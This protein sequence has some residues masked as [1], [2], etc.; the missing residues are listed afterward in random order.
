MAN[1]DGSSNTEKEPLSTAAGNTANSGNTVREG[2]TVDDSNTVQK[3]QAELAK[4]QAQLQAHAAGTQI[5]PS[6]ATSSDAPK[7]PAKQTLAIQI[8]Q[9]PE[10][11]SLNLDWGDY[12]PSQ[13]QSLLSDPSS[14]RAF[15][16]C[17]QSA[18]ET[19]RCLVEGTFVKGPDNKKRGR[20]ESQTSTLDIS[21]LT[22]TGA[23]KLLEQYHTST[24]LPRINDINTG[25]SV[26]WNDLQQSK[27]TLFR[28]LSDQQQKIGNLELQSSRRTL[29]LKNL[30]EHI[31]ASDINYIVQG[32]LTRANVD[33]NLISDKF[34]HLYP[35]QGTYL[36]II[37][38][39]E[40][41]AGRVRSY[42]K[43][44]KHTYYWGDEKVKLKWEQLFTSTDRI[45]I[46]PFFATIDTLQEVPLPYGDNVSAVR[47]SLQVWSPSTDSEPGSLVAQLIFLPSHMGFKS[48]MMV[49]EDHTTRFEAHFLQKF[50]ARLHEA[51]TFV[52]VERMAT[53]QGSTRKAPSWQ[54]SIDTLSHGNT[55]TQYPYEFVLQ[56]VDAAFLKML[57]QDQFMLLRGK[58]SIINNLQPSDNSAPRRQLPP[59]LQRNQD[60]MDTSEQSKGNTKGKGKGNTKGKSRNDGS[61][62]KGKSYPQ[63][64]HYVRDQNSWWNKNQDDEP[65]DGNS[66]WGNA[67]WK[68]QKGN[69][70]N[71]NGNTGNQWN[72]KG[73][74]QQYRNQGNQGNTNQWS[75]HKDKVSGVL[76]KL[77]KVMFC[78]L[79]QVIRG[80]G[81]CDNCKFYQWFDCPWE[82]CGSP[83][84]TNRS[85]QLCKDHSM[86]L[87]HQIGTSRWT[88]ATTPWKSALEL[89][90]S[91][92]TWNMIPMDQ[93]S[94]D[95]FTECLNVWTVHPIAPIKASK[96]SK[97]AFEL[98]HNS[99]VDSPN[100]DIVQ[101]LPKH[102]WKFPSLGQLYAMGDS[103]HS[104]SIHTANPAKHSPFLVLWLELLKV[105]I[106]NDH[107]NRLEKYWHIKGNIRALDHATV[108]LI[109]W[110]NII[111][112]LWHTLVDFLNTSGT[113]GS[114]YSLSCDTL[115]KS[116]YAFTSQDLHFNNWLPYFH[117]FIISSKVHE[118]Q[119]LG[120]EPFHNN[121]IKKLASAGSTLFDYIIM[122][123]GHMYSHP[124]APG[125][126]APNAILQV[127]Y[128]TYLNQGPHGLD[129]GV[130][131]TALSR[132]WNNKGNSMESLILRMVDSGHY[133]LIWYTGYICWHATYSDS[134]YWFS[135]QV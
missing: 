73:Q 29:V 127:M 134:G 110:P 20:Q 131:T 120:T 1:K 85:C 81:S 79:C 30:P 114:D 93:S 82:N 35:G 10:L 103:N 129:P 49:L 76:S 4:L 14:K 11:Q 106:D 42:L 24:I 65:D 23:L 121:D 107:T 34:N 89:S 70:G 109:P 36:F 58:P 38:V 87:G 96:I 37:F 66:G 64:G 25:G 32:L 8:S 16:A 56:Y 21:S 84:G 135:R 80:T 44:N 2:N 74:S 18:S 78:T 27:Q 57:E 113:F 39:T 68:A 116:L 128:D 40:E 3:L 98:V 7:A 43:A 22:E 86:W 62:G 9:D 60:E 104:Y 51:L 117:D 67:P 124:G 19:S 15:I 75:Q 26:M 33:Y 52:Q 6:V 31:K 122:L 92:L 95:C 12:D 45:A 90:I 91:K 71:S 119:F 61:K 118:F 125:E 132:H 5:P 13:L 55:L 54:V 123:F 105:L 130:V 102:P 111:S 88:G 94:L 72:S 97:E 63:Q 112:V 28:L 17:H 133:G 48:I 99:V 126:A 101:L 115:E 50:Q 53:S 108:D 77:L 83:L 59:H 46:Q 41:A 47:N 100:P 69:T